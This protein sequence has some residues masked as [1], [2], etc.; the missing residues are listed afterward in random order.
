MTWQQFLTYHTSGENDRPIILEAQQWLRDGWS[1]DRVLK[2][3][4][5]GNDILWAAEGLG[6]IDH[7]TAVKIAAAC[8]THAVP[9]APDIEV[10]T[11]AVFAGDMVGAWHEVEATEA[12][13]AIP[14]DPEIAATV[15]PAAMKARFASG[16]LLSGV[17]HNAMYHAVQAPVMEARNAWQKALRDIAIANGIEPDENG[18]LRVNDEELSPASKEKLKE[19]EV[20]IPRV[21]AREHLHQADFVRWALGVKV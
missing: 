7:D 2:E 4:H 19:L 12:I 3:W 21:E 8:V 14:D 9:L 10:V 13:T 15:D 17:N 20:A 11:D 1:F 5:V 18:V 16:R 6:V